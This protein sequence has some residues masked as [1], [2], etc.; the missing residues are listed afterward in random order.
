MI[1]LLALVAA[2]APAAQSVVEAERA[3]AAMAQRDGQWTAFRAT[4]APDAVM[5]VPAMTNAQ[6]WLKGR[7]DPKAA[8]RWWPVSALVSCDGTLAVSTGGWTNL[9]GKHGVFTTV[10]RKGPDGWR[11]VLDQ[12]H[13]TPQAVA[14]PRVPVVARSSCDARSRAADDLSPVYPAA[15]LVIQLDDAMPGA[16]A[17]ALKARAAA[18]PPDSGADALLAEGRSADGTLRWSVH[19]KAETGVHGL[20]VHGWTGTAFGVRQ[21]ELSVP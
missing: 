13:D 6:A 21:L 4:A 8:I 14:A 17:A 18:M 11:W 3:F 20:T 9:A 10:W 2:A 5:F 1:G 12:G 16:T 7:T 19:G 15:D